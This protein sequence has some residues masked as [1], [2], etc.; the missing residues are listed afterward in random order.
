MHATA[1][2]SEG[3][4][5]N[6]FK[7]K[8]KDTQNPCS[9][10]QLRKSIFHAKARISS[11]E[12]SLRISELKSQ[13]FRFQKTQWI[14]NNAKGKIKYPAQPRNVTAQNQ[15]GTPGVQASSGAVNRPWVLWQTSK[16][17]YYS[18]RNRL[19]ICEKLTKHDAKGDQNCPEYPHNG[20]N[21]IF[22]SKS[23]SKML[24]LVSRIQQIICAE[25][26]DLSSY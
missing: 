15:R 8:L 19:E 12:I 22:L 11:L 21:N 3:L 9:D 7:S 23:I 1:T 13:A 10:I 26:A 17:R 16:H 4:Q 6:T 5:I 24:K 2:A 14:V 25:L 20:T 18:L